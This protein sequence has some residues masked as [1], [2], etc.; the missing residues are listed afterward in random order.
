MAAEASD[1]ALLL[2][3]SDEHLHAVDED[4][5]PCGHFLPPP[6]TA[7]RVKSEAQRVKAEERVR[8]V[9]GAH[10]ALE[11]LE[12]V[13]QLLLGEGLRDGL[14]G[15]GRLEAAAAPWRW[16]R[17][18]RG[19]ARHPRRRARR[20]ARAARRRGGGLERRG[21]A[22]VTKGDMLTQAKATQRAMALNLMFEELARESLGETESGEKRLMGL[23]LEAARS[24]GDGRPARDRGRRGAA[25]RSGEMTDCLARALA[26]KYELVNDAGPFAHWDR[27][28]DEMRCDHEMAEYEHIYEDLTRRHMGDLDDVTETFAQLRSNGCSDDGGRPRASTPTT[29]T[30]TAAHLARV[31]TD[32]VH[33]TKLMLGP[34][35]TKLREDVV[36]SLGLRPDE[37]SVDSHEMRVLRFKN[38]FAIRCDPPGGYRDIQLVVKFRGLK[39]LCELQVHLR[40]FKDLKD[41]GGHATYDMTRQMHMFDKEFTS[42]SDRWAPELSVLSLRNCQV[43][44]GVAA[45]V[46]GSAAPRS[47]RA[48]GPEDFVNGEFGDDGVHAITSSCAELHKLDLDRDDA[49]DQEP[50]RR[51]RCRRAPASAA[52]ERGPPARP[53]R[54]PG[55]GAATGARPSGSRPCASA[56]RARSRGTPLSVAGVSRSAPLQEPPGAGPDLV[57]RGALALRE[58]AKARSLASLDLSGTLDAA[59]DGATRLRYAGDLGSLLNHGHALTSLSLRHCP[60]GVDGAQAVA[61]ALKNNRTLLDLDLADAGLGD[62]AIARLSE[63]LANKT[64][65]GW[66]STEPLRNLRDLRGDVGVRAEQRLALCDK[67]LSS[68]DYAVVSR[69]LEANKKL[70]AL[71]E[72]QRHGAPWADDA[73]RSLDRTWYALALDLGAALEGHERM[74]ACHIFPLWTVRKEE[75]GGRS[76]ALAKALAA[77]RPPILVKYLKSNSHVRLGARPLEHAGTDTIDEPPLLPLEVAVAPLLRANRACSWASRRTS[78]PRATAANTSVA[79]SGDGNWVATGSCDK[80]ARVWDADS[81]ACLATLTG[82]GSFVRGVAFSPDGTRVATASQDHTAKVWDGDGSLLRTLEGHELSVNAVAFSPDGHRL[83]TASRDKTALVWD[84]RTTPPPVALE[85]H[86]SALGRRDRARTLTLNGCA[87]DRVAED[88]CFCVGD[89]VDWDEGRLE[90]R[91]AGRRSGGAYRVARGDGEVDVAGAATRVTRAHPCSAS[92]GASRRSSA[93]PGASPASTATAPR[94]SPRCPWPSRAEPPR[95]RRRRPLGKLHAKPKFDVSYDDGSFEAAVRGARAPRGR[96]RRG[97][98][99]ARALR[100]ASAAGKAMAP[101]ARGLGDR[102]TVR[103]LS[104]RDVNLWTVRGPLCEGLAR[105]RRLETLDIA[106]N[107]CCDERVAGPGS[108]ALQAPALA[109]AVADSALAHLRLGR[110]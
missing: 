95:D 13:R 4:D 96:R 25:G 28:T 42:A 33:A 53:V 35:V 2:K 101:S 88:A 32:S 14:A 63:G 65:A 74:D 71:T 41:H 59:C 43:S 21:A 78:S 15:R 8:F 47:R 16:P 31:L 77:D 37:L 76:S 55:A 62:D 94:P 54:G 93:T 18:A 30:A 82:H 104:L 72:W 98:A 70:T 99:A 24:R 56:R 58:L 11:R 45:S 1:A 36:A 48:P 105:A 22:T 73:W 91:V 79:V 17:G 109:G 26:A 92:R 46:V 60:L 100:G 64:L 9:G 67:Q 87:A 68:Q 38:R 12:D 90:G 84:L 27:V 69:L 39:H 75:L 80:T 81:G 107:P 50:A 103:A 66:A 5:G 89:V 34:A 57:R 6:T 23:W 110:V 29:R 10:A 49:E 20:R 3:F 51:D 7:T 83:A 97:L 52:P 85:G 44:D 19:P 106:G 108:A 40:D 61:T 86:D 102:A